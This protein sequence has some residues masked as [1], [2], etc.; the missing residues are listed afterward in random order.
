[1]EADDKG[2]KKTAREMIAMTMAINK[3]SFRGQ[4]QVT[5]YSCHRGAAR[6]VAVPPVLE[7]DTPPAR[8]EPRAAPAAG[9]PQP[10][11]ADEILQKYVTALGGA[12][13]MHKIT[14]RS[15][16]GKILAG[17]NES[18][19]EVLTKA[20]NKRVTISK[21][22]NGD[23]F[24]AFDGTTGWMG[25][26]GRPARDMSPSESAASGID[27]EFY[28]ALRIGFTTGYAH[29]IDPAGII[30][31]VAALRFPAHF[32]VQLILAQGILILLVVLIAMR[33]IRYAAYL[34]A[35]AGVMAFVA[36]ATGVTDV[37]LLVGESC[38]FTP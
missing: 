1:M 9:A 11:T 7:S 29:Q 21:M 6:P 14:S 19:I 15:M 2:A 33:R 8:P 34:S 26:T 10:P 16:T 38:R 37:G 30:D 31:R 5:C 27:A 22:G 23:S 25:S 20:P 13:A 4:M 32:F 24:T 18:P 36:V 35:A 3:N 17:G 28:L 12:D